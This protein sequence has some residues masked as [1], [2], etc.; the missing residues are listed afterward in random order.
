MGACKNQKLG[1][2]VPEACDLRLARLSLGLGCLPGQL[3]ERLLSKVFLAGHTDGS[4]VVFQHRLFGVC[5]FLWLG[6]I[7][8]ATLQPIRPAFPN[9]PLALSIG[10]GIRMVEQEPDAYAADLKADRLGGI[11]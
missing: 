6:G 3:R 7:E 9:A 10:L 5:R 11:A 8:D 4:Q 1:A 2:T